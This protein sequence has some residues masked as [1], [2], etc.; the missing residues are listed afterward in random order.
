MWPFTKKKTKEQK[1][2][3]Q[4]VEHKSLHGRFYYTLELS[5]DHDNWD[6]Y[7]DYIC[8][9]L[10]GKE[11][12]TVEEAEKYIQVVETMIDNHIYRRVVKEI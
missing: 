9:H 8:F 6:A 7:H 10:N 1:N 2:K 5:N 3:Y 12:P 11:F 4:I